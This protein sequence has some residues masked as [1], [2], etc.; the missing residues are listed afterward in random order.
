VRP[1]SVAHRVFRHG[2]SKRYITIATRFRDVFASG[3]DHVSPFEQTGRAI[4]AM[5]V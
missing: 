5:S 2:D 4:F 1:I 3:H